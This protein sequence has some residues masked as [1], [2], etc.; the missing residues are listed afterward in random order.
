M[1]PMRRGKGGPEFLLERQCANH[2]NRA[3]GPVRESD[4]L[5]LQQLGIF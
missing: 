1:K 2:E 3:G 4:E 5:F